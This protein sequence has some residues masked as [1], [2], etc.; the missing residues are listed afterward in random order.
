MAEFLLLKCVEYKIWSLDTCFS[1]FNVEA[2]ALLDRR[3]ISAPW[4]A[5]FKIGYKAVYCN[6]KGN[7]PYIS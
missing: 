5:H 3:T 4:F 1:H 7:Y 6:Y 2:P